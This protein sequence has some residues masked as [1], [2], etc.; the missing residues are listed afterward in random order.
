MSDV[1]EF[2]DS[3]VEQERNKAD[4]LRRAKEQMA[5]PIPLIPE[6]P[7]CSVLL[8][9][10]LYAHGAYK[11]QAI[12]REL[13]G[14]DEEALAKTKE[15]SDFFD[16]VVAL[17]VTSIDDFDLDSLPVT[18]RQGLLRQLLLGERDLLFLSVVKATFGETKMMNFTCSACQEGQ[19][20]D[21]LLSQDFPVKNVDA[22]ISE[23]YTFLTSK[24]HELQYR[25]VTGED[26]IE[27]LSKVRSTAEQNTV[28]LSRVITRRNGEL[29]PD[30]MAFV[31]G[32]PMRDRQNILNDL[33]S[34]QPTID[35]SV[36][37][38]CA[39]CGEAQTLSLGWV[40]LFRAG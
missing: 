31:R 24:G 3:Q 25:L 2:I 19:E 7:D 32:L 20:V 34:K 13:T 15:P 37:T 17:G 10:G 4:D 11:R 22:E 27:A 18:E 29:I 28:I 12:V 9:R 5:G 21:L 35:L 39:S 40:D 36:T 1:R 16:L 38:K 23:M 8:P 33:I 26:Q 30:P 6:S 14:A